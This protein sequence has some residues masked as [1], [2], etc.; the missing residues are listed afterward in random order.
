MILFM[1]CRMFCV[2]AFIITVRHGREFNLLTKPINNQR[3][4]SNVFN[5]RT[6][7]GTIL[8]N[9]QLFTHK[10]NWVDDNAVISNRHQSP[11]H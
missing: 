2:Y 3:F 1:F 10:Y 9:T 7:N 11:S 4:K 5:I 8:I 6:T